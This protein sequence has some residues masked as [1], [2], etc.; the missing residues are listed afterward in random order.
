M[1]VQSVASIPVPVFWRG[2]WHLIDPHWSAERERIGLTPVDCEIRA[3]D[4]YRGS[5]SIADRLRRLALESE[6]S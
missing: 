5:L 6:R 4:R 2:R 3:L 1:L